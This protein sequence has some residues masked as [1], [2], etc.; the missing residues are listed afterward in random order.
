MT[1]MTSRQWTPS[2]A[3]VAKAEAMFRRKFT[4]TPEARQFWTNLRSV[5]TNEG[6]TTFF[7]TMDAMP[8]KVKAPVDV[9][10]PELAKEDGLYRNPADG[11]LYRVSTPKAKHS[12][13]HPEP[14]VS[15]YSK[16]A[17][18]RRLTIHGEAV[19]GKWL[20]CKAQESRQMLR[21]T[22]WDRT[23]QVKVLA[24]W[25]MSQQ[26]KMDY[27]YGICMFC[28]RGLEDER[29]VRHNYGPVCAKRF[30]LP[31]ND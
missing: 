22:R 5:S 31:W 19:K 11:T 20:R 6:L 27:A 8:D 17:A 7:R 15:V 2:P 12:W 24:D 23:G 21:Y 9:P 25:F 30:G 4:D 10:R 14:V 16:K 28:M 26:D 29:S 18:Q 3:Q 1:S 13:E